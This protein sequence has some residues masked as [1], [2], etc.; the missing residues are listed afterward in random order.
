VGA[1]LVLLDLQRQLA[2]VMA[3][4]TPSR[5][6]VQQAFLIQLRWPTDRHFKTSANRQV[7]IR[8]K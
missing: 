5:H 1:E 2:L 6:K 3:S 8:C 7:M 4:D